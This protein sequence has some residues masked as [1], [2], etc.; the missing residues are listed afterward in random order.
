[1]IETETELDVVAV[2]T[3]GHPQVETLE[4]QRV[5]PRSVA[6]GQVV[7]PPGPSAY[8]PSG[9]TGDHVGN[10]GCCCNRPKPGGGWWPDCKLGLVCVG[11]APG[12]GIGTSV[13]GVCATHASANIFLDPPPPLHFSQPPFCGQP[14]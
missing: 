12:P 1:V 9:A 8:C 3:A 11:N 7:T 6:K 10:L 13:Y 14:H 4:V 5:Q 2:Y